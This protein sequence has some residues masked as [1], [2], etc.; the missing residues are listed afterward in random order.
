VF[1]AA[2]TL[3]M[4]GQEPLGSG[5]LIQG[6]IYPWL[7]EEV[8]FRNAIQQL[9]VHREPKISILLPDEHTNEDQRLSDSSIT[10]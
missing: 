10:P 5:K 2:V 9:V 7:Q 8:L 3:Q 6:I 1:T 4:Q